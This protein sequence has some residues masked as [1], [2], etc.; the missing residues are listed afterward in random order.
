ML[1]TTV[2]H[3][4]THTREQFLHFCV[5]GLDFFLCVYL[6]FI[7]CVLFHGSLG[8]FVLVLLA[9]MCLVSFLKCLARD[10]EE[11]LRNDLFC[12]ELDVKP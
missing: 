6:S 2:V 10:W 5:L 1:C 9:C 3:N 8:N 4:D 12:V 11:R 7:L